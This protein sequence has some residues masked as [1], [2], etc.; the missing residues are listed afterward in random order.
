MAETF[1]KNEGEE[2]NILVHIYECQDCVLTFAVEQ[3]L[4]DQSSIVCPLC[5]GENIAD[6]ASGEL[7]V[8]GE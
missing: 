8:K 1:R 3:A 6:I 7:V 2:M 5:T 4:E